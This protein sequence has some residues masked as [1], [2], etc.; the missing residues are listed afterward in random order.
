MKLGMKALLRIRL[1]RLKGAFRDTLM[2]ALVLGFIVVFS[3]VCVY[4]GEQSIKALAIEARVARIN[5]MSGEF[6]FKRPTAPQ[7]CNKDGS[8]GDQAKEEEYGWY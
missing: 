5:K 3:Y 1:R 7:G 6:E 2:A 4:I 8:C